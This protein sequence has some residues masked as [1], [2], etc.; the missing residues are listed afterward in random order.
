MG[1]DAARRVA[2]EVQ[3]LLQE[4]QAGPGAGGAGPQLD[5]SLRQFALGASC[6]TWSTRPSHR[7][8]CYGWAGPRTHCAK[9][10]QA[11]AAR[12]TR[13]VGMSRVFPEFN[14][15]RLRPYLRPNRLSGD[16]GARPPPPTA[17]AVPDGAPQPPL[18]DGAGAPFLVAG[19]TA[20]GRPWRNDCSG[21]R[22]GIS[23]HEPR[24]GLPNPAVNFPMK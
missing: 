14:V 4:R 11:R 22:A 24:A 8:R 9:N 12:H 1:R 17:A 2:A 16:S 19:V 15:E 13:H 7:A 23:R 18:A 6:S 21:S 10:V 5:A 3:A 20:V